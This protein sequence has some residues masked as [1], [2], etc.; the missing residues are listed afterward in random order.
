MDEPHRRAGDFFLYADLRYQDFPQEDFFGLGPDSR[1]TDRTDFRITRVS[2][3][4]VLGYQFTDWFNL[5][6]RSGYLRAYVN[7]GEDERFPDTQ[8][9]FDDRSAPGLD[10]QPDFLN[11]NSAALIDF[12]DR[13]GNPHRGGMLGFSWTRFDDRGS[14]QSD[15]NRFAVDGR[16][17]LTLGSDQ[18]VLALR[19]FTS[20]DD[21]DPG[22]QV[23]FY[24]QETLE[25]TA[26]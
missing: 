14:E 1:E 12:R 26:R 9:R 19:F 3:G 2:Y 10:R 16:Y 24:L 5:A 13:P 17:Y 4:A 23:P 20:L 18:R 22:S 11:F 6:A 15:F 8:E 21:D 7:P 25:E